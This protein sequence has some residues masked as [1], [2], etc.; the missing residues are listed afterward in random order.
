MNNTIAP[1]EPNEKMVDVLMSEG[2]FFYKVTSD[3]TYD[4]CK[5][6][7]R[8]GGVSVYEVVDNIRLQDDPQ[9]SVRKRNALWKYKELLKAMA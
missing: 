7:R 1:P 8:Q 3:G 2:P 4:I 6:E 5:R 9:Q